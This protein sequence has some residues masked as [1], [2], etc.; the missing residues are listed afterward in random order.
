MLKKG[1]EDL[2]SMTNFKEDILNSLSQ[3]EEKIENKI[4]TFDSYLHHQ[5]ESFQSKINDFQ[6][7]INN[8]TEKSTKLEIQSEKILNSMPQIKN[9]SENVLTSEIKV[10]NLEKE[11]EKFTFK[12]DKI[13]SENLKVQGIISDY[14]KYKTIKDFINSTISDVNSLKT[15]KDKINYDLKN[16]NENFLSLQS[17]FESLKITNN[18]FLNER[19][20]LVEKD[21]EEKIN[22]YLDKIME[23]K[24]ENISYY[25][26]LVSDIEKINNHI[27]NFE[28]VKNSLKSDYDEFIKNS[29]SEKQ[30]FLE[31]F[32]SQMEKNNKNLYDNFD[33]IKNNF[34][35]I[36]NQFK[37]MYE[38]IKDVRFKKNM[39]QEISK[40]EIHTVLNNIETSINE[41]MINSDIKNILFEK[42]L[43]KNII[44]GIPN[45]KF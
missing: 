26:N 22:Q 23:V 11:I 2:N 4:I 45:L 5:I 8:I 30:K 44:E 6:S 3:M 41:K 36:K 43:N 25:Q 24:V 38:F 9:I 18:V 29:E 28:N 10:N 15:F 27:N 33:E 42:K 17:K 40:N 20:K 34:Q 16:N 7:V 21:Y 13:I 31:D 14:C 32:I 39:N 19:L 1:K 12:Y 37:N 35:K